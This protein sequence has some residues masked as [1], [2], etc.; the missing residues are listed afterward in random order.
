MKIEQAEAELLKIIEEVRSG[1]DGRLPPERDLCEQI[2]VSRSTL[3]KAL[4]L[5]EA[6]GKIWRHVG[7]GTFTGQRRK[8][9]WPSLLEIGEATSPSEL[10]ELRLMLEPQIARLAAVRAS[11]N[12]IEYMRYC[13]TKS[14][15]AQDPETYELWDGTLHRAMAEAAHNTLVLSVFEAVNE[16]RKLTAWGRLRALIL[17]PPGRMAHWRSQH[18]GFVEAIADRDPGTAENIARFH[19]EDVFRSMRESGLDQDRENDGGS[20]RP[21]L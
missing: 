5:L 10:M 7:R 20:T 6:R 15:A 21:A 1:P 17:S 11:P 12:E 19:V 18:R 13:L 3:R 4:D 14:E 9:G 16:L 8:E 2:G